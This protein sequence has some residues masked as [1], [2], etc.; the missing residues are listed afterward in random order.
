MTD[1]LWPFEFRDTGV[2]VYIRKVSPMLVVELQK[3]FPPPVPPRQR[4]EIGGEFV[5]EPNPA[6]PDYLDAMKAYN[7]EF[8]QRVRKLLINRGVIIP[9]VNTTWKDEVAELRQFWLDTYGKELEGDDKSLYISY[10]AV[11][12]DADLT[13]LLTAI[14]QRSQP[15]E[16]EVSAAKASFQG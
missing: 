11:G 3:A 6:H 9:E 1:K 16:A 12:T 13:D 15:T 8:E 7:V 5:E 10:L 14:M 2:T 4:V